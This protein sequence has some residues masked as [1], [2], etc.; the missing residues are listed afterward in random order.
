MANSV[1]QAKMDWQD[2][3]RTVTTVQFISFFSY[4]AVIARIGV[5]YVILGC[6]IDYWRLEL[7]VDVIISHHTWLI[8]YFLNTHRANLA[9]F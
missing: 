4:K 3:S 9:W 8:N 6:A 7:V 5:F 2:F 1:E